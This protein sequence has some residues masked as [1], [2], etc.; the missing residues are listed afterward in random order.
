MTTPQWT[1]QQEA[2]TFARV[3][4]RVSPNPEASPIQVLP[5]S[6]AAPSAPLPA[7]APCPAAPAEDKM[8][9]FLR[10]QITAETVQWR[11]CCALARQSDRQTLTT[12]AQGKLLRIRRLAA[13]LFLR[14]QVWYL[15]LA[16]PAGRL[17]RPGSQARRPA[18]AALLQSTQAF[19]LRC[20][21]AA[22]QAPP[23]EA[24]LLEELAGELAREMRILL[25]LL[26]R[27]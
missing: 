11:R 22:R 4:Q 2:E 13:A 12:L 25:D 18:Y 17:S 10:E 9:R 16:R 24:A 15:P 6:D 26:S 23:L 27:R 21:T 19:R 8:A 3:W 1:P 5:L 14:S 20:E 7:P